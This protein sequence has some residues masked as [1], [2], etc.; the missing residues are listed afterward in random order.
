[1]IE[2]K[3]KAFEP[4]RKSAPASVSTFRIPLMSKREIQGVMDYFEK[5]GKPA[6]ASAE[7]LVRT[8]HE[9]GLRV[10]PE[11]SLFRWHANIEGWPDK[12]FEERQLMIDLANAVTRFRGVI[13]LD[14]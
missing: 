14:L 2:P 10:V 8:V 11:E 4:Y 9:L 3:P 5:S 6:I 7:L 1:M 13:S 12:K